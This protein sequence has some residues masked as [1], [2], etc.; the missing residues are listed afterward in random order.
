MKKISFYPLDLSDS[1][2][3][4]SRICQAI[5]KS[6]ISVEIRPLV[7]NKRLSFSFDS[8]IYWL[9][10][11]EDLG[12]SS[13][14]VVI[15]ELI[16][17]LFYLF[18]MK[19]SK[20]KIV[21]VLHNKKPHEI[22][23]DKLNSLFIQLLLCSCEKIVVLC[24]EGTAIANQLARIDV[25]KKTYKVLH[26]SYECSP[27]IYSRTPSEQFIILFFGN[28][29]P[30]KNIE[31]LLELARIHPNFDFIISGNPM[32]EAYAD[33]LK[34]KIRNLQNVS[35]ELKFNTDAE[36]QLLMDKASIL[37]LPYH[38]ETTLNSGVAMYAFSKGINI[39]IPRI[40]TINELN[41]SELVYSYQYANDEEHLSALEE[42]INEVY[43]LYNTDYT[44]FVR[45]A[46]VLRNEI[47]TRFSV[48]A[49]SQQ[50]KECGLLDC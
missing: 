16:L 42:K 41:N 21:V 46:K 34:Q 37:V 7:V 32:N 14:A 17:K 3:Y 47:L 26:P 29:R 27:K 36:I 5:Q 28:L 22:I 35:L 1:N 44:E 38:L 39:V 49:I 23:L 25:S 40:G 45:R 13:K 30:Y 43:M 24:D 2:S 6:H 15:K 50:I 19:I 9:N 31:L 10:W 11:Y 33:F 18:L 4:I 20:G 48:E 12:R 8:D